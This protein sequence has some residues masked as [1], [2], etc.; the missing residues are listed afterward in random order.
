MWKIFQRNRS[1]GRMMGI[2][3]EHLSVLMET[4]CSRLIILD[5]RR[6]D[7]VE[8]YPYIIPGALL[9]TKVDVPALIGWLP[10]RNCVVLYA[11]DNVPKSYSRFHRLRK[12]LSFY[13][14]SDGLR[15][16]WNAGFAMET[17]DLYAGGLRVRA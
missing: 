9:T 1:L 17:V 15:A 2:S 5:L 11:T 13:V 4:L 3:T 10:P 8:H 7:E 14:L 6:R 12:D 16:W